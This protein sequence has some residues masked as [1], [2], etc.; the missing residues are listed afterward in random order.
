MDRAIDRHRDSKGVARGIIIWLAL[1]LVI[2]L[3]IAFSLAVLTNWLVAVFIGGTVDILL[4]AYV[5]FLLPT[6]ACT[7][8]LFSQNKTYNAQHDKDKSYED[9]M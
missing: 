6:L 9:D 3:A 2:N 1:S 4:G 5:V 7:S 8:S